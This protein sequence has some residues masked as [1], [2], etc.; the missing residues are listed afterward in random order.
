MQRVMDKLV[1][2]E[3]GLA[4]TAL[5]KLDATR[6]TV[7]LDVRQEARI[8]SRYDEEEDECCRTRPLRTPRIVVA[9]VTVGWRWAWE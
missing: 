1:E 2:R 8:W 4:N 3:G 6:R 9:L 5:H 7:E